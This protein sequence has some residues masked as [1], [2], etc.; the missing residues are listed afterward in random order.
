M[1]N[2]HIATANH[3]KGVIR[4]REWEGVKIDSCIYAWKGIERN[5][6]KEG[7]VP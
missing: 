6:N 1:I 3:Y 2:H 5:D 7:D 4:G